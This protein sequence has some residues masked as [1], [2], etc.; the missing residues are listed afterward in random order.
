MASE[1]EMG[2][3]CYQTV[4]CAVVGIIIIIIII[5]NIKYLDFIPYAY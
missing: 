2:A 1:M 3:H 4:F 5:I